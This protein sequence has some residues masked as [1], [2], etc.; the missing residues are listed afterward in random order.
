MCI[1]KKDENDASFFLFFFLLSPHQCSAERHPAAVY[2]CSN[3]SNEAEKEIIAPEL[4]IKICQ[5][6]VKLRRTHQGKKKEE[7]P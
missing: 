2:H 1:Y 3:I 6:N 5:M 4:D 7:P